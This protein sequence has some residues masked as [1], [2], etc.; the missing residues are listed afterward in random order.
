MVTCD[1]SVV[2]LGAALPQL[3]NG[4]EKPVAFASHFLT[5][6]EHK[7]SVCEEEALACERWHLYLYSR[8]GTMQTDH[9]VLTALLTTCGSGYK[10][11]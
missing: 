6:D 5:L 4:V 3:H 1:A 9:Q 7:Y 2:A 10:P 11:L 8:A